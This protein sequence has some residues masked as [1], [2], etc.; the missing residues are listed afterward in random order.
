MVSGTSPA[1]PDVK[2]ALT[3]DFDSYT[4]WIG[5][6]NA[7]SPSMVSRGE[8]GPIGARRILALLEEYQAPATFF[9]PGATAVT[10]PR[11]VAAIQAAGHEIG[12]HGW[13]HENPVKLTLAD[14]RRSWSA[15]LRR[16][17]R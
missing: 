6:L 15:E 2:I 3:F 10:Y 12:H 16:C 14:E 4:N 9:V 13:V 5:A 7:T 1:P 8:F 11:V 17:S